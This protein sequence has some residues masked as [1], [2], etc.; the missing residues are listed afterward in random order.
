MNG[1]VDT[2]TGTTT[3]TFNKRNSFVRRST[4]CENQYRDNNNERFAY[5]VPE[6][7]M[8]GGAYVVLTI[9][10]RMYLQLV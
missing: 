10:V 5:T 3:S 7:K 8:S 9:V 1:D 2:G 6:R 4:P